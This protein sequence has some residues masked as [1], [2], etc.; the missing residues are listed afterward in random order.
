MYTIEFQKRGL[1]HAHILLWL[2]SRDKLHSLDSIDS[3]ICAELPDKNLFTKFYYVVSNYMIHGPCGLSYTGS[4]CMKN[5]NC[6]KFY[7]K[8]FVSRTTFD[9]NGYPV[10][11][12]R[13]F[14]H[15]VT[16]KDVVLDNRSVVPYNPKLLMKY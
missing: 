9:A 3:V 8:K 10:Y 12:R 1:P 2:D 7:P 14:G 5:N 6:S 11:R 16:K 15:T 4:P 13:D